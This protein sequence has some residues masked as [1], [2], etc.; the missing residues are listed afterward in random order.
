MGCG[1]EGIRS[2]PRSATVAVA[3]SSVGLA[4]RGS[5]PQV[6]T[7]RSPSCGT[8]SV[9]SGHAPGKIRTPKEQGGYQYAVRV[10]PLTALAP[11]ALADAYDGR[12]MRGAVVTIAGLGAGD[13]SAAPVGSATDGAAVSAPRASS[14]PV[15]QTMAAVGCRPPD[16]GC[17]GMAWCACSAMSGPCRGASGGGAAGGVSGRFFPLPPLATPLQESFSALFRGRVRVG[18][19]C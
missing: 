1:V 10:T 9:L 19:L 3:G 7:A 14:A 17:R 2:W 6:L 16:G 8:P 15:G 5:R 4:G 11:A 18:Y 13:P 12:A